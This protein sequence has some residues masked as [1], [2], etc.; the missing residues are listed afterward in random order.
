MKTSLTQF[1]PAITTNQKEAGML[2][3]ECVAYLGIFFVVAAIGFSLFYS[4]WDNAKGVRRNASE[5]MAT[6]GTGERWRQDIRSATALPQVEDP[7]GEQILT[8]PEKSGDISYRFADGAL[9]RRSGANAEWTR[10]LDKVKSSRMTVDHR[11][12]VIAWRWDVEL[13]AQRRK[14]RV[15]P[16]FTFEA[17]PQNHSGL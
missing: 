2:L 10:V 3:F 14:V 7:A 15:H 9:W 8:I 4:C 13:S 17:V 11:Q 1:S 12:K 6:L 5:I 16:L